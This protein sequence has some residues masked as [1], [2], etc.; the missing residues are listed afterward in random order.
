LL[1]RRPIIVR[2]ANFAAAL[3]ML[4]AGS[5]VEGIDRSKNWITFRLATGQPMIRFRASKAWLVAEPTLLGNGTA[6]TDAVVE[7]DGRVVVREG[8]HRTRGVARDRIVIEA[9]FGGVPTAPGWL[10]F[11]LGDKRPPDTPSVQAMIQMLG[12]DPDAPPVPAR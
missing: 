7:A 6:D 10:D 5:T 1:R 2:E 8:L 11:A 4:P 12:G 9:K 3:A